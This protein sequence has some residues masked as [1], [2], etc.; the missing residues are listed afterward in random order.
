MWFGVGVFLVLVSLLSTLV[1]AEEQ[2]Y[3]VFYWM[4]AMISSNLGLNLKSR[5]SIFYKSY[6]S[7]LVYLL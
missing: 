7:C 2:V 1:L 3:T 5:A 6:V 4:Q